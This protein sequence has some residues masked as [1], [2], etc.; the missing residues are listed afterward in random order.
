MSDDAVLAFA[1]RQV[2]GNPDLA[3]TFEG[4]T[5]LFST[6]ETKAEFERNPTR[7]AA[8]NGG[9][10]GRTGPLGGLGDARAVA[11]L[12]KNGGDIVNAI[13]SLGS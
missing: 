8:A 5:Y 11:A 3:V 10:C 7:F 1:N 4:N 13:M 6:P 2:P 12:K 9:A